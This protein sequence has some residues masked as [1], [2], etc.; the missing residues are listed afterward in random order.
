MK[1]LFLLISIVGVILSHSLSCYAQLNDN[2]SW[3]VVPVKKKGPVYSGGIKRSPA[4]T[5]AKAYINEKALLIEFAS[6]FDNAIITVTNMYTN[7]VVYSESSSGTE[8]VLVDLENEEAGLY[9]VDIV[10]DEI[11]LYGEFLFK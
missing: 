8:K 1:K 2:L 7:H 5:F 11:F 10:M 3:S 6:P 9:Q 4:A